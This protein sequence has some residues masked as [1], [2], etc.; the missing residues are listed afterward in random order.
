MVALPAPMAPDTISSQFRSAVSAK[1]ESQAVVLAV[2]PLGASLIW[3]RIVLA[4][5][6]TQNARCWGEFGQQ[7]G[8]AHGTIAVDAPGHGQS[9]HDTVDLAEAA[10]LII[11][12]GGPGHYV[13]YSMGG[14]MLLQG[15]LSDSIGAVRSLVLI[16]ASAGIED[17][18]G[19]A[20]RV[21]ADDKLA[22]SL[23]ARGTPVFIDEWLSKPLFAGLS[24]E[25]SCKAKRLENSAEGMAASLR[26]CGTGT[27]LPLWDRLHEIDI[28]VLVLAGRADTKFATLG[29]RISEGIGDNASFQAIHGG[30][31]VHLE[32]PG[33]TAHTV[34]R[35]V[36][37]QP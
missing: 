23:L 27:Q 35:W 32:N 18:A 21:A 7:L 20:A 4:H 33:D 26:A 29:E 16:G 8:D 3:P 25:Q 31:A 1:G 12:A 13:G 22:E 19:R 15:V 36:Q 34:L 10:R 9:G 28:P 6:F 14:R 5:G 37:A 17:D 30:H 24:D 2:Q 11:E